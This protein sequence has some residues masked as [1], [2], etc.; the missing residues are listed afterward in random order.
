MLSLSCLD[1]W[2]ALCW[3]MDSFHLSSLWVFQGQTSVREL[4][5]V[6]LGTTSIPFH[7]TDTEIA[8]PQQRTLTE[9]G[10]LHSSYRLRPQQHSP[11]SVSNHQAWPCMHLLRRTTP[12]LIW[13]CM[14]KLYQNFHQVVKARPK[15]L[16]SLA[17]S[18]LKW[19]H[20]TKRR[21][22]FLTGLSVKYTALE[23]L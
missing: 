10:W 14:K 9:A 7:Y 16:S 4:C 6:I 18:V 3:A 17:N 15:R 22:I 13:P 8:G 1:M 23:F 21:V 2:Q 19:K 20:W 12:N 5:F 11:L